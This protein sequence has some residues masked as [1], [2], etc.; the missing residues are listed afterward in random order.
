MHARLV[1][2]VFM[3]AAS[4][5]ELFRASNIKIDLP[6]FAP[7]FKGYSHHAAHIKLPSPGS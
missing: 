7:G 1:A 3:T 6:W 5:A 2:L 4:K